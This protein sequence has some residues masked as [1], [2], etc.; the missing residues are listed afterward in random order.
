MATLG[1]ARAGN[2]GGA[3]AGSEPFVDLS[4]L[5]GAAA[6]SQSRRAVALLARRLVLHLRPTG[7]LSRSALNLLATRLCLR[8]T[9]GE[10]AAKALRSSK[11]LAAG[12]LLVADLGKAADAR[13]LFFRPRAAAVVGKGL[14]KGS[15]A[16]LCVWAPGL[17]PPRRHSACT[18]SRDFGPKERPGARPEVSNFPDILLIVFD[19]G[20]PR[21]EPEAG[22]DIAV[23]LEGIFWLEAAREESPSEEECR[24]RNEQEA[25]PQT[26]A[27]PAF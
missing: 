25:A 4:L 13:R 21:R 22:G 24:P 8:N 19:N 26:P 10:S 15:R 2:E 9:M 3:A 16:W 23:N 27:T 6:R 14:Q 7:A 1:K 5:G 12:A 17:R 20:L 18:R 11:G